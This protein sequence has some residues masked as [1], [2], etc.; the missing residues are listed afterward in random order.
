MNNLDT[1][2]QDLETRYTTV[3]SSAPTTCHDTLLALAKAAEVILLLTKEKSDRDFIAE[4]A[5]H[6]VEKG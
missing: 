1:V 4:A 6:L 5:T 3:T 2:L